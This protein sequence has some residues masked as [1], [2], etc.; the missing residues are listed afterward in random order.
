MRQT[1]KLENGDGWSSARGREI[2]GNHKTKVTYRL[3]DGLEIKN[4][5]SAAFLPYD[6]SS[7]NQSKIISAE[8]DLKR[9]ID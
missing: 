1:F 6:W 9:L 7:R 5:I 8:A 2:K 4:P 3:Q